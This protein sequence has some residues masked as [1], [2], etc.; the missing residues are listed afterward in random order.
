MEGGEKIMKKLIAS[1]SV[2]AMLFVTTAPAFADTAQNGTTGPLSRNYGVTVDVNLMSVR[3]RQTSNTLN[4]VG[5]NAASGNVTS[6][7]NTKGGSGTSGN[8][9]SEVGVEN[10]VMQISHVNTCPCAPEG[11]NTAKNTVTGPLS[12]NIAVVADVNLTSVKTVQN[13]NIVN[14]VSSSANTGNVHSDFN[15]VGGSAKSGNATS[16]VGI[17]NMV[18]QVN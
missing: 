15:T 11:T 9:I 13:S 4:L 3:T 16:Y 18:G 6:S 8:A 2:V 10:K 7:F 1:G 14:M 5:S 12:T 17:S